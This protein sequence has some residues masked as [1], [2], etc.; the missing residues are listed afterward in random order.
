MI[1]P[2]VVVLYKY[3]AVTENAI[4]ALRTGAFWFAN[5]RSFNDPYDCGITVAE[6]ALEDS[7]RDTLATLISGG[8]LDPSSVA[9][10]IMPEDVEAYKAFRQNLHKAFDNAGLFCLTEVPSNLLMW[11]HYADSHRGFCVGFGRTPNNALGRQARP[12]VY[13]S[14]YPHLS[15]ANFNPATNPNSIDQLWLVKATDWAYEREWRIMTDA[16]NQ[17]YTFDAPIASIIFGLRME[18]RDRNSV[19]EALSNSAER[20]TFYEVNP[21]PNQFA[22]Q[23]RGLPERAHR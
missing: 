5:P 6:D 22:F 1:R 11:S 15:A 16:G 10:Q 8:R 3:C 18:E 12:V 9:F 23:L 19:R 2:D 7:L 17:S 14:D 4:G 21:V 13:Q 20:P